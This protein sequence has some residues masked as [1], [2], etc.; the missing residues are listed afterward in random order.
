MKGP[1]RHRA[2]GVP[3][4]GLADLHERDRQAILAKRDANG[5]PFW[6]TSDG[7]WGVGSPFSTFDAALMLTELGLE[8][9]DPI[10]IGIADALFGSWDEGR[11][12][13]GPGLPVQPCH[14][15]NAARILCRLGYAGDSRLIRTFG[16]LLETRNDDGGWRCS[17]VR[18][19]ASADT[20][21]SNPG[22]T[23]AVLDAFRFAP[24]LVGD[25]RLAGAVD[26]LLEHWTIRRPLGP[27][28]FGIGSRFL[29]V[30][31]PCYRYNLFSYVY[32]LSF[33]PRATRSAA[34]REAFAALETNLVDGQIAV[35]SQRRG[36]AQL[37]FCRA[38]P[39]Q[40]ATL[41]FGEILVNLE[42]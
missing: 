33:Y 31:Y 18:R 40:S 42:R 12:R 23:L 16:Q 38:G 2:A 32:V 8:R 13:P 28:R 27:C 19:G 17:V 6:T 10:A 22:V 3:A 24:T 14:T 5:G 35:G 29:A 30:E 15:A 41:R 9:G 21:A 39:S 37:E 11:F 20:D 4:P 1:P 36:L 34:F 26:T 25:D 7:R